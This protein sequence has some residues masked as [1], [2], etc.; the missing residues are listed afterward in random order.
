MSFSLRDQLGPYALGWKRHRGKALMKE[1]D[2]RSKAGEE[3]LLGLSGT[4]GVLR[5]SDIAQRSAQ[6][7]SHIGYKLVRSGDLICNKM[8]AWNGVFGIS[9]YEGLTSPDYAIYEF[10]QECSSWLIEYMVRTQLYAA[11]FQSRSNGIGTGFMRLNPAEFLS[12]DFWLPSFELQEEIAAFL[13]RETSRIDGLIEKKTRFIALLKE[14]R[15]AVITHAV[16]KGIDPDAPMKD[17]GVDWL[18][19]VLVSAEHERL[20]GVPLEHRVGGEETEVARVARARAALGELP[21]H[22]ALDPEEGGEQR[23]HLAQPRVEQRRALELL[24]RA[25]GRPRLRHDAHPPSRP[26]RCRP[27]AAPRAAALTGRAQARLHLLRPGGWCAGLGHRDH[28]LERQRRLAARHLRSMLLTARGLGLGLALTLTLSLTLSLTCARAAT[29]C[30]ART[31][32]CTWLGV[33]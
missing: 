20:G 5:K 8:Q 18:G 15:A 10:I 6:A 7:E 32:P 30:A 24:P 12:T 13:D 33:G 9:P 23:P 1:V 22:A 19:R 14:K 3:E 4:K 27:R 21:Q 17:S 31:R 26:P 16:T 25:R 11:D 2:N 28:H 29:A